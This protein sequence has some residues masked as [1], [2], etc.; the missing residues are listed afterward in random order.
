[1]LV[2][3]FPLM[4]LAL[5]PLVAWTLCWFGSSVTPSMHSPLLL[6]GILLVGS[7]LVLSMLKPLLAR[8]APASEP[9]YLSHEKQPLLFALAGSLASKI[10][11]AAPERIAVDCNVNCYCMFAGRNHWYASFRL[12]PNDWIAAGSGLHPD[13]IAGV[14]AHELATP[15]KLRRCV[16]AA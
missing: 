16:P 7:L 5:I 9:R 2:A 10:G 13:Q 14:P 6:A 4:Y 11:V 8:P 15:C 3:L 12:R 1:M